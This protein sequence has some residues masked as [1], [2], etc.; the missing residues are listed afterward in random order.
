[1][2]PTLA[3]QGAKR[4]AG[5]LLARLSKLGSK[6]VTL[7]G[8]A[9]NAAK[10]S[11]SSEKL[12]VSYLGGWML[13]GTPGGLV[14]ASLASKNVRRGVG[15]L[16]KFA[17]KNVFQPI[18][19]HPGY[20]ALGFSTAAGLAGIAMGGMSVRPAGPAAMYSTGQG[21]MSWVSGRSGGMSPNHL[22]A[23]GGLTLAMHKSRHRINNR[24]VRY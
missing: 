11:S 15:R 3:G 4:V 9:A 17:L 21:Y 6:A 18:T 10:I 7:V 1:M 22:G 24:Q 19:N 14:A 8:D 2:G 12:A 5:G 20:A 23:T 13:G 16:G